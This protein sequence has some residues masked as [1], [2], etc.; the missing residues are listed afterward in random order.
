MRLNDLS[1]L[2]D[3]AR[4]W[5][6]GADRD[7]SEDETSIL[8]GRIGT[9]L[10][11]WKAHAQDLRVG[12]EWREGRFLLVAVDERQAAASGCSIDALVGQLRE[13]ESALGVSLIDGTAIW[14]RDASGSIRTASRADFRS[15][16]ADGIISSDTP[17]FDL[18]LLTLEQLRDGRLE[19]PAGQTWHVR[20]LAR[21][22]A[23]SVP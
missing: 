12:F 3:E 20:L 22:G 7:L 5:C 11:S 8:L 15:M 10:G 9:F 2:P 13:I 14:F 18:T 4:L 1:G 19:R 23:R 6:F 21:T 17:V 16:A